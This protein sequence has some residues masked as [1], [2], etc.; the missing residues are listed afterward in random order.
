MIKSVVSVLLCI[1]MILSFSACA[2]DKVLILDEFSRTVS[3]S[4][5]DVNVKGKLDFKNSD[6]ITF[7]VEEPENLKGIT[8]SENTAS[9]DEITI[10]YAKLKDKSPVYILLSIIKNIAENEIYLPLKGEYTFQGT[11]SAVE[12]KV[13]F[14]CEN[15]LISRIVTEKFSYNFE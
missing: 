5:G 6:C 7:T 13:V 1:V 4:M 15:E 11:V 9:L 8:F 10:S 14:D 3:F 2:K 12:Y